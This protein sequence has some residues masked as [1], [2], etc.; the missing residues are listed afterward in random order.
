M[1]DL[2]FRP[3]VAIPCIFLLAFGAQPAAAKV[4]DDVY[5]LSEDWLAVADDLEGDPDDETAELDVP[6]LEREAQRLLNPTEKLARALVETGTARTE[7]LGNKLL[8]M[9]AELRAVETGELA[10]Y[11]VDRI[12]DL[13]VAMD[14]IV[15]H[16]DA[17]QG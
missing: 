7:E 6:G 5:S 17:A 2:H 10:V 14:D 15:S 1:L 13:I 4:C 8:E 9:V 11:L 16:C 3:A 12:E